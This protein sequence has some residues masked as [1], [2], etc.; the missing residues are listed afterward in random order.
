[1]SQKNTGKVSRGRDKILKMESSAL[2]EDLGSVHRS[3]LNVEEKQVQNIPLSKLIPAPAGWNFFPPISE[4]KM[5]EMMM[6][7]QENGLFNPII[8]WKQGTEYMILSGHNRVI[9]YN[10]ILSEYVNTPNFNPEEFSSIP[11]RVFAEDE[12]NE[13]K[14][15]EI[16]IDTNYIQRDEDK[17]LLPIIIKNRIEITQKRKDKKGRTI[18]IVAKELG[19]GRT[20]IYEDFIIGE[21]IIP[22]ISNL[23][24][25]GVITKKALLRFAWYNKG[26][27]KYLYDQCKKYITTQNCM[28]IKKGMSRNELVE[29]FK[30]TAK[31]ERTIIVQ[32]D[33]P[34]SLKED[35]KTMCALWLKEHES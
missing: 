13:I 14:A 35:F 7:I 12:I 26:V 17:R 11:S 5:L 8:L 29:L 20:K 34:E 3:I 9:A 22:E 4:D 27:Q 31:E 28:K 19:I 6:S 21:E 2:S 1:M 23:F 33:V 10:R 30:S 25:D 16:I 32:F 18:D 24:F 15:R